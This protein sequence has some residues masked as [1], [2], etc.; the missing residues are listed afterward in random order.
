MNSTSKNTAITFISQVI[1]LGLGIIL[2][3]IL[4]RVLGPTGKL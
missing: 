3:I 1:S 4:A 2:I